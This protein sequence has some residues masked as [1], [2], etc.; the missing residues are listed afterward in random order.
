MKLPGSVLRRIALVAPL[1]LLCL[2]IGYLNRQDGRVAPAPAQAEAGARA[3]GGNSAA[4]GLARPEELRAEWRAV[5]AG[6]DRVESP[7]SAPAVHVTVPWVLIDVDLDALHFTTEQRET[8]DELK[9]R[10]LLAMGSGQIDPG[11]PEYLE[12]WEKT[13]PL[14]DQQTVMFL[15][16]EAAL[17]YQIAVSQAEAREE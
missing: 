13:Q 11:D 8:I 15:G 6:H 3:P 10:F 2:A 5:E 17:R 12:R 4:P 7:P 14:I 9:R 1:V 16:D